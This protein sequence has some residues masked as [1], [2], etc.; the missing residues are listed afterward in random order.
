MTIP[1]TGSGSLWVKVGHFLG[2]LADVA[3]LQGGTATARVL[4]TANQAT[5]FGTTEADFAVAPAL[6]QVVEGI[7]QVRSSLASSNNLIWSDFRTRVTNT[8]KSMYLVDQGLSNNLSL[9]D[10]TNVD[11]KT[12]LTEVVR[13]MKAS[14][15]SI[16]SATVAVGAQTAQGSPVGTPIVVTSVKDVMGLALQYSLAETILV[17][18]SADS[19]SGGA[20][21]GNEPF[22]VKGQPALADVFN[23]LWPG[24]SGA[25][26]SLFAVDGTK[27]N[28][29]GNVL[30]NSDFLTATT[31]NNP[32]NWTIQIGAAGT[33]VFQTTSGTYTTSGG[34]L[35]FT[36]TGSA[37]LDAVTQS[38]N[39]TPSTT[40]AAGG[41][42]YVLL[43][44][45]VYHVNGWVKVSAT[46]TAGVLEFSLVDGTA[47]IGTVIN[48]DQAVANT[49]TKAITTPLSTTYVAFNGSFQ[50]P[51]SLTSTTPLRL[52]VRLS[53]AID[54][55]KTVSI[56]RLSMTPATQLYAGGPFFS[57]HSGNTKVVNGVAPDSWTL[58]VTND[59]SAIGF[60]QLLERL[61][62]LRA[63]GIVFP[64]NGSP[65]IANSLVL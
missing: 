13:Q 2:R 35:Q 32:D 51:A 64:F 24:G 30:Q 48:N 43:P 59:W 57:I 56:G 14:V 7:Q 23:A 38:F 54:S 4:S 58:A 47:G 1:L 18:C 27:N 17:R 25:S 12:A 31:A 36:G 10:L 49:F 39:T 20:T 60:A 42:S 65:T 29:T 6:Y 61:L 45:T 28:S 19:Q 3:A 37:L 21:S 50:T 63:L 26:A 22:S 15:D 52:R 55:G 41:T 53:T 5:L 11:L 33:D 46:P 9:A 40:V 34:A 62:G 16:Q 44:S 8:F